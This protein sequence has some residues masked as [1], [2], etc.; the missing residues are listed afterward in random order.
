MQFTEEG[1]IGLLEVSDVSGQK[2]A[3][4]SD[5]PADASIGELVDQ[6]LHELQLT[7]NDTSG[8]PLTYQARLDREGRHLLAS[9]RVGEALKSGDRLV[10]QPNID[11]GGRSS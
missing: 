5:L 3:T 7:R 1:G 4:I 11:A 8:R 2:T 10:L 9:E 6:L